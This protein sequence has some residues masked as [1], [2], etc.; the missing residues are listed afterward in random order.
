MPSVGHPRPLAHQVVAITTWSHNE[1][2]FHFFSLAHRKP[3]W[4]GGGALGPGRR[5]VE[6]SATFGGRE[7]GGAWGGDRGPVVGAPIQPNTVKEV[8]CLSDLPDMTL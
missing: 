3:K 8:Q 6:M 5:T 1:S 4:G 7:V 2:V